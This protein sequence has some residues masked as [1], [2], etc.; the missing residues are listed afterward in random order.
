[1]RYPVFSVK[2]RTVQLYR[3]TTFLK[4]HTIYGNFGSKNGTQQN[5]TCSIQ[6]NHFAT[7]NFRFLTHSYLYSF[8][9]K[10]E[11][12]T[13]TKD[14]HTSNSIKECIKR[15]SFEIQCLIEQLF[16]YWCY[17]CLS[18][19]TCLLAVVFLLFSNKI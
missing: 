13:V 1:M 9:L 16:M 6:S 7:N 14:I 18:F 8:Q 11:R 10:A 15:F 3:L 4:Q 17:M 5:G 2:N 19:I 12:K